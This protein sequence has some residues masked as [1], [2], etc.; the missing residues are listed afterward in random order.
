MVTG[1]DKTRSTSGLRYS[2]ET[3]RFPASP[4]SSGAHP[5]SFFPLTRKRKEEEEKFVEGLVGR[6]D[7]D[8]SVSFSGKTERF[9][10][11]VGVGMHRSKVVLHSFLKTGPCRVKKGLLP[12]RDRKEGKRPDSPSVVRHHCRTRELPFRWSW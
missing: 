7:R 4:E 8:E 2:C 3:S 12:G 1:R 5:R 6:P 10:E 9:R 11:S